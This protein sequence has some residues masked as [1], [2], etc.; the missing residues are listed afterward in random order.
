MIWVREDDQTWSYVEDED[1][2]RV[3]GLVTKDVIAGCGFIAIIGSRFPGRLIE[4][5]THE[6]AIAIV[7]DA[8]DRGQK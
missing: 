1:Q 4:T 3:H 8:V 5:R 6:E 2:D 7:E